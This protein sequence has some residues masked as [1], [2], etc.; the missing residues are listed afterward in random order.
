MEYSRCSVGKANGFLEVETHI[1]QLL[2]NFSLFSF[3]HV[4]FV[5]N[6]VF[7]SLHDYFFCKSSCIYLSGMV[8]QGSVLEVSISN[9]LF[10]HTTISGF[11]CSA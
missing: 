6:K 10:G 7:P 4:S 1:R 5:F 8:F 2:L 3:F 11:C 9:I